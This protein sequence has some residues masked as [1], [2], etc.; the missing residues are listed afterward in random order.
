VWEID[1]GTVVHRIPGARRAGAGS[2]IGWLGFSPD[3][4]ALVI[5]T[6]RV[7]FKWLTLR[8]NQEFQAAQSPP[9]GIT[10]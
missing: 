2:H 3:G 10:P 5:G 7:I 1:R 8:R 6:L 4:M 9:E